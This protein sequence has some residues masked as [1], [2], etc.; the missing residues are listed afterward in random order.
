M[1]VYINYHNNKPPQNKKSMQ[2][3]HLYMQAQRQFDADRV[4]KVV[5]DRGNESV[6]VDYH[7]QAVRQ[8][9]DGVFDRALA[10][11]GEVVEFV[12]WSAAKGKHNREVLGKFLAHRLMRRR[13]EGVKPVFRFVRIVRGE[14]MKKFELDDRQ[15]TEIARLQKMSREG[16]LRP[17]CKLYWLYVYGFDY[18]YDDN[19]TKL[20]TGIVPIAILPHGTH[21]VCS[22]YDAIRV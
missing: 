13:G 11:K 8:W 20:T 14:D 3:V 4:L 6:Y 15:R 12:I 18:A 17:W 10:L 22:D 21:V 5:D 7:G 1:H 2:C 16:S 9:F 19:Y